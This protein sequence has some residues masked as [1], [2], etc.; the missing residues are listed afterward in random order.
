[1]STQFFALSTILRHS[2]TLVRQTSD[3]SHWGPY[4]LLRF[5]RKLRLGWD[6]QCL[7][8][9]HWALSTSVYL[10]NTADS[11]IPFRQ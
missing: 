4:L 11:E 10:F 7:S 9:I 6:C 8:R 5:F 2:S 3:S 1:M